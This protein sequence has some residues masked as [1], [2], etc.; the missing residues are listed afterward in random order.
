MARYGSEFTDYIRGPRRP[1]PL[2]HIRGF[3]DPHRPRRPR[4]LN[5]A[6]RPDDRIIGGEGDVEVRIVNGIID[7]QPDRPLNINFNYGPVHFHQTCAC[8]NPSQGGHTCAPLPGPNGN[9]PISRSNISSS[10]IRRHTLTYPYHDPPPPDD[11]R[12]RRPGPPPPPPPPSRPALARPRVRFLTRSSA[13]RSPSPPPGPSSRNTVMILPSSDS[14]SELDE[15]RTTTVTTTRTSITVGICEGCWTRRRL[16]SDEYCAECE[17]FANGGST[18]GGGGALP[19]RSVR[20][21]LGPGRRRRDSTLGG[22]GVRYVTTATGMGN[23]EEEAVRREMRERARERERE[24]ERWRREAERERK[25]ELRSGI[26]RGVRWDDDVEVRDIAPV[27]ESISLYSGRPRDAAHYSDSEG[28]S[29][30]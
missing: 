19:A 25:R 2:A 27:R 18:S 11:D 6:S 4:N 30:W 3:D 26:R 1:P 29:E 28:D 9:G 17:D 5:S 13:E 22:G 15:P 14:S 16:V 7:E 10:S 20:S 23:R 8:P 12:R 21:A 24:R